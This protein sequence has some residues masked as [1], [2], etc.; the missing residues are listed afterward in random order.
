MP[1]LSGEDSHEPGAMVLRN[2]QR[3]VVG[4]DE[5]GK[6][7]LEQRVSFWKNKGFTL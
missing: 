2:N 1:V 5:E 7:M 6:N 3:S 4:C